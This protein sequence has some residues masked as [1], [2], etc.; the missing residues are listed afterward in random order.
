MNSQ[1]KLLNYISKSQFILQDADIWDIFFW[2]FFLILGFFEN[3]CEVNSSCSSS[4]SW[5]PTH[6]RW[7]PLDSRLTAMAVT[8]DTAGNYFT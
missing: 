7:V 6:H 1:L 5:H 4:I 2:K 8:A 3:F